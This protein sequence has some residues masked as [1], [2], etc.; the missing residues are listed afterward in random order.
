M[1]QQVASRYWLHRFYAHPWHI[2]WVIGTLAIWMPLTYSFL[3]ADVFQSLTHDWTTPLLLLLCYA[4]TSGLG[5]FVGVF[6][7][8]WS[9]LPF[10]SRRNGAPHEVGESV[11]VLS[12]SH[13]GRVSTIYEITT[14]QGGQPLPRIDLDTNS[15]EKYLDIFEQYQLLRLSPKPPA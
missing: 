13:A 10:C 7:V 2:C 12:G 8:S 5:Y 14:G 15:R 6:F 4:A 1:S 9:V 3:S 11:S